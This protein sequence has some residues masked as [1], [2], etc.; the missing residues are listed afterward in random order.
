MIKS[1]LSLLFYD[2]VLISFVRCIKTSKFIEI[3]MKEKM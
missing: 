2:F 1:F 3:A